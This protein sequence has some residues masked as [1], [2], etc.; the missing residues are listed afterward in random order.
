[1]RETWAYATY[2][3]LL[4]TGKSQTRL[5]L[6]ADV[7]PKF[8]LSPAHAIAAPSEAEIAARYP[9]FSAGDVDALMADHESES[10][11]LLRLVEA[12]LE[13]QVQGVRQLVEADAREEEDGDV[14][15]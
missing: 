3:S 10:R 15:M 2:R 9:T 14:A 13:K 12:G 4:G 6:T 11:E 7:T 1:M 5:R 8:I